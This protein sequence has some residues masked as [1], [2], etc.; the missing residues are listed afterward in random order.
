M[1][2]QY[3]KRNKLSGVSRN[4]VKMTYLSGF[5]VGMPGKIDNLSFLWAND[6]LIEAEEYLLEQL[7]GDNDMGLFFAEDDIVFMLSLLET[8]ASTTSH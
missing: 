4:T 7:E 6:K 2:K 1:A 3:V 8:K 5:E